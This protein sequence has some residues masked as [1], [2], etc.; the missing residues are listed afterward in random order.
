M[1]SDEYQ[2]YLRS[3]KWWIIRTRVYDRDE[4]RCRL[5]TGAGD[6]VHHITY[7]NIFREPDEDL[8]T[9][10]E[11]C[12]TQIHEEQWSERR[13]RRAIAANDNAPAYLWAG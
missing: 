9:L 5:C 12:H 6:H 10:C 2:N 4:G 8:V 11:D 3:R 7:E 1:A 13:Q